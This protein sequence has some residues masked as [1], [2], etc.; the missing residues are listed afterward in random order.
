MREL[1]RTGKC[2]VELRNDNGHCAMMEAASAGKL[3]D[4]MILSGFVREFLVL[5]LLASEYLK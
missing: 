5:Y 2:N 1:L 3:C 4:F